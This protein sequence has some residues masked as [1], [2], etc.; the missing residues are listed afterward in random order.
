MSKTS[1]YFSGR[2]F[3][4]VLIGVVSRNRRKF[5]PRVNPTPIGQ[6]SFKSILLFP[7]GFV[8]GQYR[9]TSYNKVWPKCDCDN[10]VWLFSEKIFTK[11]CVLDLTLIEESKVLSVIWSWENGAT[12]FL[13]IWNNVKSSDTPSWACFGVTSR[14]DLHRNKVN[15]QV[16]LNG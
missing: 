5:R 7:H 4:N 8:G 1:F 13:L 16:C 9:L 6:T 12:H 2:T 14:F 15:L 10:K 11:K 3:M